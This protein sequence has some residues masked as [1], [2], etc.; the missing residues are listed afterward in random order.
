MTCI[1]FYRIEERFYNENHRVFT[2]CFKI[3]LHGPIDFVNN[4]NGVMIVPTMS[5]FRVM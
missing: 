4:D 5:R 2:R 3:V 1:L